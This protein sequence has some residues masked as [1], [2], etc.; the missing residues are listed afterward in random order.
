MNTKLLYAIIVAGATIISS[1]ASMYKEHKKETVDETNNNGYYYQQNDMN[2]GMYNNNQCA[3][4][5][6]D[7][8]ANVNTCPNAHPTFNNNNQ[9]YDNN[10]YAQNIYPN[11]NYYGY[12]NNIDRRQYVYND[13][14]QGMYVNNINSFNNNEYVN[15][16]DMFNIPYGYGNNDMYVNNTID[17]DWYRATGQKPYGYNENIEN[18]YYNDYGYEAY[19]INNQQNFINDNNDWY[20]DN[21][22]DRG[23]GDVIY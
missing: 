10:I 20:S 23:F 19:Q 14:Y 7:T 21:L 18:Y 17:I 9:C 12:A 2:N 15:A 8:C 3:E 4:N 22:F 11:N 5:P 16:V 13:T 6:C 1:I